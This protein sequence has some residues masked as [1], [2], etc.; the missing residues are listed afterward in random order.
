MSLYKRGRIWWCEF[1]AKGFP[2]TQESTGTSDRQAAKE[3]HDRRAAELWRQRRLGDRPRVAFA[4]AAADWL[5]GYSRHKKSHE[6]DKLHLT[7][8]VALKRGDA[9]MLP[10]WLDEL[11]TSRM[12]AIRDQLRATR[13]LSAITLNKYLS[14]LSRIWHYAHEREL[15]AAVPAIPTFKRRQKGTAKRFTVMTPEQAATFFGEL[16]GHLLPMVRF[17]LATGLRDSNVRGLLWENVDLGRRVARVWGEDAKAGELIPVPLSDDAVGVLQGCLGQHP[18][19]VFTFA[20]IGKKGKVLWRRPITSGSNNTAFRN[21]RE[22][23]GLPKLRWHDLRHTW[24]TWHAQAGTP[25]IVLQALGGWK[26]ARMV[27]TYTHL[28]ATDLL[29]HAN[30]IRLPN[31]PLPTIFPTV[32]PEAS[33]VPREKSQG[34][35]WGGRW[36]SN[37]QQP[38]SQDER[39][40]PSASIIKHMRKA[41][42]RQDG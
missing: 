20:K 24:A 29:D 26:D 40:E 11:T 1:T 14:V 15:V 8:M 39:G 36:D 19:H 38:E 35:Q 27:R 25:A 7:T 17:A 28:A 12:T 6:D 30:A 4:D 34:N 2:K 31:S 10:V 32:A 22:R 21:A 3:Y 16:P 9:L 13:G 18:T 42:T 37:P 5:I 41:K 23:A 33:N